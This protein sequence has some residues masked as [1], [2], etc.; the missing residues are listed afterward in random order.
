MLYLNLL[1]F[2]SSS[3][4]QIFG[5]ALHLKFFETPWSKQLKSCVK[6][7]QHIHCWM[8]AEPLVNDVSCYHL[9]EVANDFLAH[10]EKNT[11]MV[12]SLD[13]LWLLPQ[14]EAYWRIKH[15]IL[16]IE[17]QNL[18]SAADKACS[19]LRS[20][21][22]LAT[23]THIYILYNVRRSVV[24]I[25]WPD[26]MLFHQWL[27]IADSKGFSMMTGAASIIWGEWSQSHLCFYTTLFI[28]YSESC[29]KYLGLILINVR[30]CSD[31]EKNQL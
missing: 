26:L 25:P 30:G 8:S 19:P 21:L 4:H 15:R 7:S 31:E 1:I 3:W 17:L 29:A 14:A 5:G 24:P 9:P 18:Q 16:D 2:I 10:I 22:I 12:L 6:P 11:S 20:L 13:I 28:L 27:Y 23:R